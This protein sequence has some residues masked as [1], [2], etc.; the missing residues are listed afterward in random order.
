M[1]GEVHAVYSWYSWGVGREMGESP[2]T[3]LVSPTAPSISS[4]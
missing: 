4:E 1:K 3:S 2:C